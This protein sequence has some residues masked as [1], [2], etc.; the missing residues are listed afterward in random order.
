MDPVQ[1]NLGEVLARA[2][3]R[4]RLEA[5][6]QRP[7]AEWASPDIGTAGRK[8]TRIQLFVMEIAVV[9]VAPNRQAS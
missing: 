8:N 6:L 1:T 3:S 7:A 9:K 5:S 2:D 4:D